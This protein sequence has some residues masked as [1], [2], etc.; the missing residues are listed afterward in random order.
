MPKAASNTSTTTEAVV[1][2]T[3]SQKKS[4]AYT[5]ALAALREGHRDEFNQHLQAEYE[6]AG[7]EF[8]PR[9]TPAEK[10]KQEIEALLAKHPDLRD[11]FN[12]PAED[13]ADGSSDDD[14]VADGF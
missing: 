9:L 6:K 12:V 4:A 7:L 3:E 5:A 14:S 1:E 10:A 11:T 2:K 13:S 8:K